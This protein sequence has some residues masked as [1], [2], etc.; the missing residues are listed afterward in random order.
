MTQDLI[1]MVDPGPTAKGFIGNVGVK[2]GLPS[3]TADEACSIATELTV[4]AIRSYFADKS[5]S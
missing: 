2:E 3:R 4:A 5:T 1:V